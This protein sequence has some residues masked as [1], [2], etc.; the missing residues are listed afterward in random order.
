MREGNLVNLTLGIILVCFSFGGCWVNAEDPYRYFTFQVT[1][2]TRAP[3]GVKQK[4]IPFLIVLH[5]FISTPFHYF[6]FF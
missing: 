4:V 3:L 5:N 6:F 2:G 1:Y